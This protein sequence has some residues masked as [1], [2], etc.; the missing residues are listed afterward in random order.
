M[1]LTSVLGVLQSKQP[2][3]QQRE[4]AAGSS[5]LYDLYWQAMKAL[6]VQYVPGGGPGGPRRGRSGAASIPQDHR[7]GSL[8]P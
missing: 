6:G 3:L 1:D 8:L 7:G 5:R 4:R 2:G